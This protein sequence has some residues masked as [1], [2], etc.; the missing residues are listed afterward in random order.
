MNAEELSRYEF[1]PLPPK[2]HPFKTWLAY[3]NKLSGTSILRKCLASLKYVNIKHQLL[4]KD[5][6]RYDHLKND[7]IKKNT[8]LNQCDAPHENS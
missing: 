2:L 3:Y 1:N 8:S 4:K 5:L 6:A 7:L